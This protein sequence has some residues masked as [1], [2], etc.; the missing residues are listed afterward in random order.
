MSGNF[1]DQFD[2]TLGLRF[3][4]LEILLSLLYKF[5]VIA[6]LG[7]TP[8]SV[9]VYEILLTLFALITHADLAIPPRWDRRLRLVLQP[10]QAVWF[11]L[12]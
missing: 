8:L 12:A 9:L 11:E 10:G 3:H 4:P 2:V 5:V 6:L 1:R 7:A